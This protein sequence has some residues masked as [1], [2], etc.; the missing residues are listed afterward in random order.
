MTIISCSI[1]MFNS[2]FGLTNRPCPIVLG[3]K[4]SS[5]CNQPSFPVLSVINNLMLYK[6]KIIKTSGLCLHIGIL[7]NWELV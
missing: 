7:G 6:P 5:H 2:G 1:I 3:V 4:F